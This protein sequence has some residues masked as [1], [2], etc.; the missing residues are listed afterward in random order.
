[1]LT[2][3]N[4]R[5]RRTEIGILRAIGLR[6]AQVLVIFIG[7]AVLMGLTGAVLGCAGG[8]VGGALWQQAPDAAM[9]QRLADPVLVAAVFGAAPL[10]AVLASWLPALRAAQ[11]DPAVVLQDR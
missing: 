4:V 11:E 2:V 10:L 6:R 3:G 5:D 7:K 1:M 9:W 8:L